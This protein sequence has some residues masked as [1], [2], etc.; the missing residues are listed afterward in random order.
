MENIRQKAEKF[1]AQADIKSYPL[2][3]SD[4]RNIAKD[5]GFDLLGY[6]EDNYAL[7]KLNLTVYMNFLNGF[8]YMNPEENIRFI[9]YNDSLSLSSI[10]LCIAHEIGHIVLDHHCDVFNRP[11]MEQDAEA[12]SFSLYFLAPYSVLSQRKNGYRLK[13]VQS[14]CYL[15]RGHCKSIVKAF[16]QEQSKNSWIFYMFST[17]CLCTALGI[18]IF[19]VTHPQQDRLK[20]TQDAE[21][22][23]NSSTVSTQKDLPAS[24]ESF[25][26]SLITSEQTVFISQGGEKYHLPGCQYIN[27]NMIEISLNDALRQGYS[28]CKKC[29]G[30]N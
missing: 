25:S 12:D 26:E 8:T 22:S 10:L 4:L 20:I 16:R 9:A 6:A 1:I 19:M 30:E 2:E 28:P 21:N 23:S 18:V 3:K 14:I 13:G 7:T 29:I 11:T 24:S 15:N 17:I 27:V 5:L